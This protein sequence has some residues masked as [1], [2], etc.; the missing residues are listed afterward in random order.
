V[1]SAGAGFACSA[2]RRHLRPANC[3]RRRV[4]RS[5]R[6]V[7]TE[8]FR[9]ESVTLIDGRGPDAIR[10]RD[11]PLGVR[12]G[13]VCAKHHNAKHAV[14]LLSRLSFIV[15][16][17]GELSQKCPW[18]QH[19]PAARTSDREL[20]GTACMIVP[21][22]TGACC[23]ETQRYEQASQNGQCITRSGRTQSVRVDLACVW[24][25]P[26]FSSPSACRLLAAS[27]PR[28]EWRSD[29]RLGRRVSLVTPGHHST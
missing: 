20:C 9:R 22:S 21:T 1:P 23:G 28:G 14:W 3:S 12:L 17:D 5:V 19:A 26:F 8:C 16:F 13:Q 6:N 10:T 7:A 27:V 25:W 18:R 29:P 4:R 11:L 15:V 24:L 2:L